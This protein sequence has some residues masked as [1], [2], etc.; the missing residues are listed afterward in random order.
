M[1]RRVQRATSIAAGAVALLLYPSWRWPSCSA[2]WR[3]REAW[4]M[5]VG[6]RRTQ[7][8]TPPPAGTKVPQG[9]AA[10]RWAPD[11]HPERAVVQA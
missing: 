5:T 8:R 6:A 7:P 10:T 2:P 4:G 1:S 11:L 9:L 3:V